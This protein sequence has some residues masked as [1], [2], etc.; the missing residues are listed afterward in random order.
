M[1]TAEQHEEFKVGDY[2]VRWQYLIIFKTAMPCDIMPDIQA[3][4]ELKL[5]REANRPNKPASGNGVRAEHM[6]ASTV[7]PI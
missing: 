6:K 5:R 7:L 3:Y 1:T 4:W 2:H